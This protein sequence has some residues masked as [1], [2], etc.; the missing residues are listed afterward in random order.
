MGQ[1]IPDA[2][3]FD[4]SGPLKCGKILAARYSLQGIQTV[5]FI[6]NGACQ[7]QQPRSCAAFTHLDNAI[8]DDRNAFGRVE[9]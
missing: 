9:A 7:I 8:H 1:R 4:S 3:G 6:A 2:I 5:G